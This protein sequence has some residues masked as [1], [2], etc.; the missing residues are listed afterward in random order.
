M[1]LV[2]SMYNFVL[3]S[4]VNHLD[5]PATTLA[6]TIGIQQVAPPIMAHD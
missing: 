3:L 2:Q 5:D 6:P 1:G 4:Q